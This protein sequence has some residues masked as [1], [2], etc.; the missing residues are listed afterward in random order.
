M[1]GRGRCR[2]RPAQRRL[3]GALTAL[4]ERRRPPTNA[5]NSGPK[6]SKNASTNAKKRN[7]RP[8]SKAGAHRTAQAQHTGSGPVHV[9]SEG[10]RAA[11]ASGSKGWEWGGESG[12]EHEHIHA[13]N[14]NKGTQALGG[15]RGRTQEAP[16]G[17]RGRT[18]E[19]AARN[20]AAGRNPEPRNRAN[21]P[22]YP[23][24]RAWF[25]LL[26]C[27][28][29]LGSRPGAGAG[30]L[31]IPGLTVGYPAA[32]GPEQGRRA[33]GSLRAKASKRESK[34]L[35]R[36]TRDDVQHELPS[37]LGAGGRIGLPGRLHHG[38]RQMVQRPRPRQRRAAQHRLRPRPVRDS[39]GGFA[40][41]R[42]P[43][44]GRAVDTDPIRKR[45]QS[46]SR[47]ASPTNSCGPSCRATSK[48]TG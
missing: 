32:A 1:V 22:A 46:G 20:A 23:A 4:Q 9:T 48:P 21:E 40:Q 45:L 15:S 13:Q 8:R 30:V 17:T 18:Q 43:L 42:L 28:G 38:H 39:E 37:V 31:R 24:R 3:R 34:L 44:R 36:R 2:T 41:L 5:A 26:G 7:S 29:L 14:P 16:R 19:S 33:E 25:L 35:P 47:H 6:R 27:V 11:R 12:R 10:K